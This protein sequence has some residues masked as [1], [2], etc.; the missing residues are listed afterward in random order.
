[1]STGFGADLRNQ[2]EKEIDESTTTRLQDH[3]SSNPSF[4]DHSFLNEP[5]S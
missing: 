1:V 3:P 4:P 2:E 5:P